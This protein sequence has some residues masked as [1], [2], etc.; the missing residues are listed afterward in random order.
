LFKY[1]DV[2]FNYWWQ[3]HTSDFGYRCH[4]C[5]PWT[6]RER[7]DEKTKGPS[8]F[9]AKTLQKDGT[10]IKAEFEFV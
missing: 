2:I 9:N 10:Q 4:I 8:S 7:F 1:S 3:C 5:V 6:Q